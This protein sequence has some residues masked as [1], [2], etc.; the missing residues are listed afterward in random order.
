MPNT[1]CTFAKT[2]QA[3]ALACSCIHQTQARVRRRDCKRLQRHVRL[4]VHVDFREGENVSSRPSTQ[5]HPAYLGSLPAPRSPHALPPFS[6]LPCWPVAPK[7]ELCHP[8]ICPATRVSATIHRLCAA[9]A[10]PHDPLHTSSP[11]ATARTSSSYHCGR[12]PGLASCLNQPTEMHPSPTRSPR[13]AR[14]FAMR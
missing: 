5:T 1:C 4:D 12:N 11:S 14:T 13:P 3:H 2:L 7:R 6:P 10:W 9:A 8:H